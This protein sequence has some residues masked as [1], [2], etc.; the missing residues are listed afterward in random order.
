M[1]GP[2]STLLMGPHEVGR[3]STFASILDFATVS[4]PDVGLVPALRLSFRHSVFYMMAITWC[5]LLVDL[6]LHLFA[7]TILLTFLRDFTEI[8]S[9]CAKDNSLYLI[10]IK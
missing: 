8:K 5:F 7:Y 4:K 1:K 6:I 2:S 9:D 10:P 3:I